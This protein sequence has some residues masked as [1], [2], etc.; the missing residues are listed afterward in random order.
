MPGRSASA[1]IACFLAL[2]VVMAN[3]ATAHAASN[4]SAFND[5][6]SSVRSEQTVI[7]DRVVDLIR[8]ADPN[9]TIR[10]TMFQLWSA[11]VARAVTTPMRTRHE[12]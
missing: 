3:P 10:I 12:R 7:R 11:T 2:A 8:R 4:S 6:L 9:S 5:P 1:L